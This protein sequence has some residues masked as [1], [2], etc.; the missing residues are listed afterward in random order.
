MHIYI[1]TYIHT[2]LMGK[3]TYQKKSLTPLTV[4]F[5]NPECKESIYAHANK[6]THTD[7]Q[8][9]ESVLCFLK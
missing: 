5:S 2:N 6:C 4:K 1:H 7:T 9:H 3:D 8:N